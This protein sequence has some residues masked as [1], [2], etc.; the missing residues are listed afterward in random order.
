MASNNEHTNQPDTPAKGAGLNSAKNAPPLI[1]YI[2]LWE[3]ERQAYLV[4]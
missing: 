4:F 2:S 3:Y 1:L